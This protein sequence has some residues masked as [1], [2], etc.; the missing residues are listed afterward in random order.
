MQTSNA[1]Q[2]AQPALD[3]VITDLLKISIQ[4][5]LFL[6]QIAQGLQKDPHKEAHWLLRKLLSHNYAVKA[7]LQTFE[8]I[9]EQEDYSRT[10]ALS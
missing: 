8:C 9:A 5:L 7:Y 6:E 3:W 4:Q 2:E 10:G 1:S